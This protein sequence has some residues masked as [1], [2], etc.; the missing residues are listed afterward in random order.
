MIES[1][2]LFLIPHHLVGGLS[3]HPLDSKYVFFNDSIKK[4]HE[5]GTAWYVMVCNVLYESESV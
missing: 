2:Y 5:Y 3:V 4:K 1:E